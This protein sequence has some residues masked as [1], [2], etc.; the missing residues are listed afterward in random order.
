[1]QKSGPLKRIADSNGRQ[2][3]ETYEALLT[4]ITGHTEPNQEQKDENKENKNQVFINE[5]LVKSIF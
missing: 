2:M 4:D 1:M 3:P 5:V